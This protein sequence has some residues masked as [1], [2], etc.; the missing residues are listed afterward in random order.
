MK[1]KFKKSTLIGLIISVSLFLGSGA[2]RAATPA[3][4]KE[5]AKLA[6]AA[7]P[8]Q[9]AK[10]GEKFIVKGREYCYECIDNSECL[11]C[12]TKI[13]ER[14]FA[15]SVHGANSC[16]SCH[17]D[18]TDVKTHARAKGARIYAEPVP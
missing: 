16:N 8:S 11:G 7:K 18:I 17:Y 5:G 15:Q 1:S 9:P 4:E 14:K 13:K 6:E 2:L 10:K 3:P 12:H